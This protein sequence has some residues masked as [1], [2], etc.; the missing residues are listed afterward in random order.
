MSIDN[1]LTKL[2]LYCLFTLFNE[3]SKKIVKPKFILV[4]DII[5]HINIV[6]MKIIPVTVMAIV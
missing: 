1:F 4:F 2:K 5:D 3:T 6:K